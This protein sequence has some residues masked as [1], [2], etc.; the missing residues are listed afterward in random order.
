[1]NQTQQQQKETYTC[2]QCSKP[3]NSDNSEKFINVN[4]CGTE[5]YLP[6]GFH[7]CSDCQNKGYYFSKNKKTMTYF[8]S[9]PDAEELVLSFDTGIWCAKKYTRTKYLAYVKENSNMSEEDF[10][11]FRENLEAENEKLD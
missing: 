10:D 5:P 2:D 9:H 7:L 11:E 1:M 8:L 6:F 4:W 3:K